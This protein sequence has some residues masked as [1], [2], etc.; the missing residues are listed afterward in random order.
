[1]DKIIFATGNEGK[2]KEVRM[3][4]EDLGL[5]VLSLKDAGITAD[6]EENGTTFEENAQ[7]KAKAIMEMTGA[8]VLA[9][10]SGLEVD[11]LD[12]EPGIYSAR[13]MGHD[14]SYHIKN[15]N[16]IDRLEGKVG[17]E[18]SARFVCAIAAAFPDGRVLITRGTMEGQIGYEEKGENGF[19]YDPIFYLPEYQCYSAELS[20]EEK[21]KL[22]HRG[23]ALRLMKERLHESFNCQ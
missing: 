7:I 21:N 13:Y 11:A 10:D 14:T 4:L 19:G 3:I 5:P 2:M 12:K 6:V 16:I 1:M 8:L 20:L 9:D 23:K 18:R 15:Q 22:S 17:E